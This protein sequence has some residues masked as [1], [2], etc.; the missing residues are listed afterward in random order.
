MDRIVCIIVLAVAVMMTLTLSA[1]AA[2]QQTTTTDPFAIQPNLQF[3]ATANGNVPDPSTRTF[4]F[5]A[6]QRNGL[7]DNIFKVGHDDAQPL[8]RTIRQQFHL[9]SVHNGGLIRHNKAF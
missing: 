8:R 9:R 3:G 5:S 4:G 6:P 7:I 1:S 2:P